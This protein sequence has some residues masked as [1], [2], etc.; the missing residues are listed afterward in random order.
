MLYL[1]LF[2]RKIKTFVVSDVYI[3]DFRELQFID[4]RL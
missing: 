3:I 2:R 1:C 4:F